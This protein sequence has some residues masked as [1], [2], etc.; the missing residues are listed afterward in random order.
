MS[1]NRL[2]GLFQLFNSDIMATVKV[3]KNR[4]KQLNSIYMV[5][6][7]TSAQDKLFLPFLSR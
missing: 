3:A 4:D 1:T 5:S 6:V 2:V 7:A